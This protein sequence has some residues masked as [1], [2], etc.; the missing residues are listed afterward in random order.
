MKRN[1][2]SYTLKTS[3]DLF[4]PVGVFLS[5]RDKHRDPI[6]LES[7]D[8]RGHENASS[9][10]ACSPLAT[11]SF[12]K[13]AGETVIQESKQSVSASTESLKEFLDSFS[14]SNSMGIGG[15][16]GF[17]GFTTYQAVQYFEDITL[18]NAE[19]HLSSIPDL[20]YRL[21]EYVITINH[22]QHQMTVTYNSLS[23]SPTAEHKLS[24]FLLSLHGQ[25]PRSSEF[26][27]RGAEEPLQSDEA[28]IKTVHSLKKHIQRGDIFQVVPSRRFNQKFDGDEFT[29]YRALRI[30]NPSPYLFYFS[31]GD[32]SLFGSSPEAQVLIQDGTVTLNPIA[33]T[34]RRTGNDAVDQEAALK[35]KDDPKEN[36]EHVMLVDLARND[37]SKFCDSVKVTSYRE[38]QVYSHVIHLVSKVQ[39]TL[40][41]ETHPVDM[42]G[43]SLP[44][45]TVSGAPKY[46]AMEL[47][48]SVEPVQRG[49]YAGTV[50]FF[51]PNG[52]AVHAI[53]IR[54]F[55]S[56]DN[57]LTYQAG[58]GIVADSDPAS[59]LAEINNKLGALRR[60]LVTAEELV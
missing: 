27:R 28:F 6:L 8:Y 3:A 23:P 15:K 52:N 50:G 13:N 30:V 2:Y 48:D 18:K 4:T 19:T 31:Y 60:A 55:L 40:R 46:R 37:L 29:L 14:F 1:V 26:S 39:G 33:G 9:I 17:F 42:F 38:I 25:V 51:E 34:Y 41:E 11:I 56:R 35:L 43:A 12:K 10:I 59:E 47:I 7:S 36:A 44:A 21:Y 22:A 16:N 5:L 45:G 49:F 53:M 57:L 54:S 20:C 32:F 58:A 24:K